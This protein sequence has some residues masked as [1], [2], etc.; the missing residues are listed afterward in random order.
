MATLD[1]LWLLK[2]LLTNVWN[3]KA[4][5]TKEGMD[6][7]TGRAGTNTNEEVHP[8]VKEGTVGVEGTAVVVGVGVAV[9]VVGVVVDE[10]M[11]KAVMEVGVD[12]VIE[13]NVT[14]CPFTMD[15]RCCV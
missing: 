2:L 5:T 14:G 1:R 7:S 13:D 12:P 8:E 4:G 10:E 15:H 3:A 11:A 9:G 6:Q